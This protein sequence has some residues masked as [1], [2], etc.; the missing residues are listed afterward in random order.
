M[1]VTVGIRNQRWCLVGGISLWLLHVVQIQSKGGSGRVECERQA[2]GVL[3]ALFYR[4]SLNGTWSHGNS[5]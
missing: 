5:I 4:V 1:G 3:V 2:G